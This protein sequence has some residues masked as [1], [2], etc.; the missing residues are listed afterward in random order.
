MHKSSTQTRRQ[1]LQETATLAAGV[2]LAW[3]LVSTASARQVA[4]NE[5]L[6]IGIIGAGGRGWDN[7]QGVKSERIVAL[8]DV[9]D[10]MAKNA[11]KQFPDATRYRDFREMLDKEKTLDA[12]VVSTPDHVHATAAITA[13]NRGLH[14]YCEKPLAHTIYEA[15]RMSEVAQKTGVVTQM[16]IQGHAMEGTRRAVEVVRSG[17]IG[18]VKELHVWTDRPAGWWPQG[19]ERPKDT[20]EVPE[21]LDWDLWLGPAPVRPYNAVYV[22]FKWRGRWDFGTGAIGDMGVHDLDTA[23]WALE[24]GVPTSADVVAASLKTDDCPPLASILDI[25]YPAR[26]S[27]PPVKLLFYDGKLLPPPEL[28]Q[29]EEMS[30]NGSLMIGTKGTLYTRTWHGGENEK[31]MFLL[32]PSKEFVDYKPP[33]PTLPRTEEHHIEWIKAC[34]GGPPTQANFQYAAK[35]TEGL[36]V[37]QLAIRTGKKIDWDEKQMRATGCTEADAFIRPQFRSGWEV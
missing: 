32:L 16:G 4:A 13:M 30:D 35:L 31:D 34:K 11:F 33:T 19:E 12:V 22:P 10:K 25:R 29:G 1:F 18:D 27:A 6:A 24:L 28:F 23:F 5:K 17:A 9:D 21:T 15:R 7:L 26:G 14:V 2:S 36:L 20:P 8:A 3:P 37:G